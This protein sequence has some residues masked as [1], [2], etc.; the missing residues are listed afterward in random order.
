MEYVKVS[1]VT[2]KTRT[3]LARFPSASGGLSLSSL[4]LSCSLLGSKVHIYSSRGNGPGAMLEVSFASL[5]VPAGGP[6]NEREQ[7]QQRHRLERYCSSL[8]SAALRW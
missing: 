2:W 5:V 7:Q 4:Y 3:A 6:A 1:A 8:R